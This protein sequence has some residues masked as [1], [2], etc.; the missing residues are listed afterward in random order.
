MKKKTDDYITEGRL[1]S[2]YGLDSAA[3]DRLFPE[4]DYRK[5]LYKKDGSP[6]RAWKSSTAERILGSRRAREELRRIRK[7]QNARE[8]KRQNELQAF[9][10]SYSLDEYIQ[11]GRNI[12]RRFFLHVGETNSGK[13]Y[14]SIQRMSQCSN[15]TYL[16]PLRLLALEMFEKLNGMGCPCDLITGEEEERVEDATFVSSTIEL[17]DF[18]RQYDIAVIDEAQMIADPYRGANWT[19]AICLVRAEEVHICIAPE[20]EK[21]ITD[22]IRDMDQEYEI[23]RHERLAPLIYSGECSGMDEIEKGDCLI[24]FSRKDVLGLAAGL[25]RRGLKA[26]VIYGALPPRA[27]RDEVRRFSEGETQVVVATDAIGMGISLPIR[28]IIFSTVTKFDG[29]QRRKLTFGEIKQIAGRAGR[30][31]IYDEGYVLTMDDPGLVKMALQTRT[32]SIKRIYIPFPEEAI[33]STYTFK[34]LL[35]GWKTRPGS[36]AFRRENMEEAEF[37]FS[38]L[39]GEPAK[40]N[41]KLV[42]DLITCSVDIKNEALVSYWKRCAD[43]ILGGR[44]IPEPWF[45]CDDLEGCELQYRGY[46]VYHQLVAY[47]GQEDR[48][49]EEKEKIC[50]II[51]ELMEEKSA[52]QRRCRICGR[53]LPDGHPFAICDRCYYTRS[54]DDYRD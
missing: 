2:K 28:R 13:T 52:Y 12:E 31:G 10:G 17:C 40:A 45:E 36:S 26:S 5:P 24:A 7:E 51:R 3:I 34:E 46:D 21:I 53:P 4:P 38:L 54:Y 9:L 23:V 11:R 25:E 44:A 42:Y 29:T 35:E 37:L 6:Q 8:A 50:A 19:K 32:S 14:D 39:K 15:G 20:A 30:Y 43:S 16:A 41:R 49:M 1:I 33:Y 18:S 47:T 27:R 48:S 22:M